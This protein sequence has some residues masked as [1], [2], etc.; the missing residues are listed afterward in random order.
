[1]HKRLRVL[2]YVLML[3]A[4]VFGFLHL[5]AD[6]GPYRFE[7]LHVFLF[8]LCCGG[9]LIL[10]YTE[11]RRTLSVRASMFL[12]LAMIYAVVAFFQLYIA[13]I[14]LS[15][16]LSAIVESYRIQTF[17]LFPAG[18]FKPDEPVSRKFHQASLLCL[19]LALIIAASVIL[20][21]EYL[22]L[23]NMPKLHLDVF[24]LGFSFPV[25]LITMSLIFSFIH[26]DATGL[27][28][29]LKE[30]SFWAVN[31]GVI[32][33]FLFII[34]EQLTR[35]VVVT[36]VLFATVTLIFFLYRQG[37][38]DIQQKHFLTSGM[39]FLLATAVTGIAYIVAQIAGGYTPEKYHWLLKL[40]SFASLYGWNLCG[41]AVICRYDDF[42]IELHARRLIG[43]HWI[44]VMVMAPLG[45][46]Y[47]VPAL[48]CIICYAILLYF[49]FF[50]R[51]TNV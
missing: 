25:S 23:V 7:R 6:A 39:W 14:V 36:A 48:L 22:H 51:K 11:G 47:R 42:P 4:L 2:F 12:C 41:L 26:H 33:F 35:Q 46:Y 1:M 8:N 16:G 3:T 5:F 24:F 17:S 9:T 31:L 13:A 43:F 28:R 21:N 10:Y 20:N 50:S 40:H 19:S 37:G 27:T 45:V 49:I 34:F 15:L 29:I 30:Y 38:E 32:V 18:F 44:T